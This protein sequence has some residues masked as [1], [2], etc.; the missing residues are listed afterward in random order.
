MG[1][2]NNICILGASRQN[3]QDAKRLTSTPFHHH[4]GTRRHGVRAWKQEEATIED[5]EKLIVTITLPAYY[6]CRRTHKYTVMQNAM[7]TAI[8]II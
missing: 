4:F 3:G 5:D 1:P 6:L 7:H 8:A 2:R